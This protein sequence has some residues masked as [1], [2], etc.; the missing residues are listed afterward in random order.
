MLTETCS[1]CGAEPRSGGNRWGKTCIAESV[2][3]SREKQVDEKR[4][5]GANGVSARGTDT[6][7][8]PVLTKL[9]GLEA[10]RQRNGE[11]VTRP[12]AAGVTAL[13]QRVT[14]LEDEVGR[15]KRQLASA[16]ARRDA[17]VAPLQHTV[18]Q[19]TTGTIQVPWRGFVG[20]IDKKG[21]RIEE[22]SSASTGVVKS[23]AR[24]DLKPFAD[25]GP[26]CRKLGC[27]C[28]G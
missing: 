8:P 28:R 11:N 12:R 10:E 25:H 6:A 23:A 19:P 4:G 2:K 1:K 26:N 22:R 18:M 3:R 14:E 5:G 24:A 20:V 16:N 15:L 13:R 17:L 7:P 27:P 21:T 9:D